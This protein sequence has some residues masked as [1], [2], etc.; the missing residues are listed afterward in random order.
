MDTSEAE[1]TPDQAVPNQ[2]PL[3]DAEKLK[4]ILDEES[5]E[6]VT[7]IPDGPKADLIEKTPPATALSAPDELQQLLS[8]FR[9]VSNIVLNNYNSDREQI[10]GV[11]QFLDQM[12]Q[13][14]PKAPRV[15]V[16]ML[17]AALRTKAETN[18]NAVKLLDS[19]A[20]LLSA[21]KGT[22][23]FVNQGQ[24][25]DTSDLKQLLDAPAYPDEL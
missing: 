15:Y 24:S 12:V 6:Q 25:F 22:N 10:E 1:K 8:R 21:G 3:T 19:F 2:A 5:I 18:A 23:V 11:I 13:M 16:E 20:K 17:V 4:A 9:E 14:G 7:N